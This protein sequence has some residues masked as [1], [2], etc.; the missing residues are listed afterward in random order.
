[1]FDVIIR[2]GF[3]YDSQGN[4]PFIADVA[5]NG[6]RITRV[7]K[8]I[9]DKGRVEIDATNKAIIPGLIDAHVHEEWIG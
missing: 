1:M 6:D 5:I 8:D 7:A 2:N 4:K 9:E 3:T